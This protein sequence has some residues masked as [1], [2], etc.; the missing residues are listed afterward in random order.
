MQDERNRRRAKAVAATFANEVVKV[1]MHNDIPDDVGAQFYATRLG[2][3]D[4]MQAAEGRLLPQ[5]EHLLQSL[6]RLG[7]KGLE[8]RR[9][10]AERLLRENGVT[11]NVYHDPQGATRPWQLDPIPLLVGSDEWLR[12]ETGLTQRAELLDLVLADVYGSQKLIKQGLLP[13]ELVYA[14]SG[15]QRPCVH[16]TPPGNRQLILYAANLARGPEGRMWVLDDQSQ[17]PSGAGY[18]LENRAVMTRVLPG[19]FRDAQV[20]RLAMFFRGLR[21]ALA[22][23]APHNRDD[24][25]VV[26]LTPGPLNETY[27][28]HAYLAAFLGYPLAQG[29]DLTVRDGRV[30][31]K[32]VEGL[33]QVDVILRR[34]DDSFCDPLELRS[35]SLL[36]IPGLLE[37]VR[38]GHVTLANPVG[39]SVLENPGLLP[40]LP[41]IARYFLGQELELP[42]VATWWC[43]QA[44]ERAFVL[45]NIDKLV[46]RPIHRT[47][48]RNAVFGTEL[49]QAGRELWRARILA[50]PHMYVGQEQ[51]SFS[52]VPSLVEGS[53]EPRYAILRSFLVAREHDYLMMPG[54]LTRIAPQKGTFSVSGQAGG[55]SKDTWVLAA[56]P[57]RPIDLGPPADRQQ[58]VQPL[59]GPLPSRAAD[60]LFWV[61]RYAE[62]AES[63]ARLMRTVLLKL[64]EREEFFDPADAICLEHLLRGLTHLTGTYPGF[65]GEG[66]AVRLANPLPELRSLLL[67]VQRPDSLP[68]TLRAFVRAAYTVRDLWSSDAW[69]VVDE[70]QQEWHQALVAGQVESGTSLQDSLD[71]LILKLVAFSGLTTESMAHDPGWLMLD[72]GRRL[73][74]ALSSIALLRATLVPR[75]TETVAGQILEAVLATT[76]SLMTFRRRYRSFNQ[77]PTVLELLLMDEKHP[78]ALAYQLRKL[79]DHVAAL[80]RKNGRSGRKEEERLIL[81]AYTLVRLAEPAALVSGTDESGIYVELEDLLAAVALLLSRLSE[82]LTRT[83]FSHAQGPRMLSPDRIAEEL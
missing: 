58:L 27:F 74:R 34:L 35:D 60:N 53:I 40:F 10:E 75:Q 41:G 42:S 52:T 50:R 8:R 16:P 32:S 47:P 31:L 33:Q 9:Q 44:R 2:T 24:P 43:G 68:D 79:Q 45:E 62:R 76:E 77:L 56:E 1:K 51:V 67:N 11:Y 6:N 29:D 3:Y 18:A 46:I 14:H 81:E 48:G 54:G 83:Y 13:F 72:I 23:L 63:T 4:E 55:V 12:L 21:D 82:A 57:E 20:Q 65:V 61:G 69:R 19:L 36:G 15:F 26:V 17:A 49:D 39:S 30:W 22:G 25:R 70:I 5:W 28:E 64:D 38:R 78:R 37:A 59:V 71:Q 66:A 80:P 7:S 73:E